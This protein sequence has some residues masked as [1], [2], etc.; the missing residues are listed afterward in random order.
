M[1]IEEFIEVEMKVKHSILSFVEEN[2]VVL[3]VLHKELS[4]HHTLVCSE[5]FLPVDQ[6]HRTPGIEGIKWLDSLER[7]I[8]KMLGVPNDLALEC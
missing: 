3:V 1:M 8:R 4:R 5:P 6:R 7:S 2:I